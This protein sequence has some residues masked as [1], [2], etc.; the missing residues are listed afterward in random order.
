MWMAGMSARP[1]GG[2][3]VGTNIHPLGRDEDR[4]TRTSRQKERGKGKRGD[5]QSPGLTHK[6]SNFRCTSPRTHCRR[7]VG[8]YRFIRPPARLIPFL[9]LFVQLPPSSSLCRV[10]EDDYHPPP[11]R[12]NPQSSRQPGPPSR[13]IQD[14][15]SYT[16]SST[17][18][19]PTSLSI[20]YPV[21]GPVLNP[22][23]PVSVSWIVLATG[24]PRIP[25]T[26]VGRPRRGH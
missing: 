14:Q 16:P 11:I 22:Q 9:S 12:I 1:G 3:Y 19:R 20:R 5:N 15:H 25:P 26:P 6:H 23:A 17:L 13:V 21:Y 2:S 18:E 10:L 4:R 7:A 8:L 24:I